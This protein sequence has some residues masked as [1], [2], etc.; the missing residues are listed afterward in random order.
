[1]PESTQPPALRLYKGKVMH[2]RL[3]ELEHRFTYNVVSAVIDLS[4]LEEAGKTASLFKV[5]RNGLL[6]F[7]EK[8]FGSATN[9][10]RPFGESLYEYALRLARKAGLD[11]TDNPDDHRLWVELMFYPRIAGRAFNPISVY[12]IWRG[13]ALACLIYEVRNTFGEMHTYVAP[14]RDGEVSPAGIRQSRRKRLHVSPFMDMA[15]RYDFRILPPGDEIRLRI[16]EHDSNGP[17]L[18]ASFA[19]QAQ[20]VSNS[21]ILATALSMGAFSAKVWLGIHYEALKL[22]WKGAKFRSSPPPPEAVSFGDTEA[23]SPHI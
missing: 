20:T 21:A 10:K 12:F 2:A 13:P 4:R 7:H 18:A 11:G 16:L 3:G 14:V 8:D 9:A 17:S 19:G 22:W 1:M 5:N 23:G 15:Q 6:S